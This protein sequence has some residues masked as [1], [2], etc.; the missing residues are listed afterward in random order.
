[1]KVTSIQVATVVGVMATIAAAYGYIRP[2]EDPYG[3]GADAVIHRPTDLLRA[4]GEPKSATDLVPVLFRRPLDDR[5]WYFAMG[6]CIAHLNYLMHAG[7]VRRRREPKGVLKHAQSKRCRDLRS[8]APKLAK[9][10]E[11]VRF[12]GTF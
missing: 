10:L 8:T 2:S 3:W 7:K 9:R 6:E 4:C 5:G 11:C 12:T 1:M